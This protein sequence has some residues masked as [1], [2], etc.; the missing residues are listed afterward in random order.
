MRALLLV[1]LPFVLIGCATAP[2][3][4]LEVEQVRLKMTRAVEE[5][6][7]ETYAAA[8]L[9]AARQALMALETTTSTDAEVR[10][11]LAY[12]A[13]RR[14]D[15]AEA[16]A[17]ERQ[18]KER[19]IE[20]QREYDR[21]LVEAS[22]AEADR[23]R[24]EA[25]QL[26][27]QSI[28]SAEEAERAL[29]EREAAMERAREVEETARMAQEEADQ[30]NRLA[31]A[32]AREADLAR[33]EAELAGAEISS[34]RRQLQNLQ[35]LE[36]DRG[37]MFTLGDVLFEKSQAEL[38]EE[39]LANLQRL[40]GFIEG[41]PDR[42]VSIEGHTDSTG[43]EAFNLTLS[44]QRAEAVRDALVDR[45]IPT[46]RLEAVGLGEEFPIAGNDTE[47]GRRQNRRVEIIIL[48]AGEG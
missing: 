37:L 39:S 33:Q 4:D 30:A 28:A 46:R 3:S 26:R 23:A 29:A 34:L 18:Q 11:H 14:L 13:K 7:L 44:Q 17:A 25:E 27:L 24:R 9:D 41:Y 2:A 19:L 47:V 32:R 20:L 45:G 6:A 38:R 8:E 48:K 10:A 35:A 15:I 1:A 12:V 16:R 40:V 43:S 36:T 21:I 31:A 42:R 22:L 5:D